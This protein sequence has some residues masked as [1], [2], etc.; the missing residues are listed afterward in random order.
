M[1]TTTKAKPMNRG[2]TALTP[3]WTRHQRFGPSTARAGRS[4]SSMP[5]RVPLI[6]LCINFSSLDRGR[7]ATLRRRP[8]EPGLLTHAD[9]HCC[10]HTNIKLRRAHAAPVLR[11]AAISARGFGRASSFLL[12]PRLSSPERSG[13]VPRVV[14][15]YLS[16]RCASPS[17][18][19][20][21]LIRAPALCNINLSHLSSQLDTHNTRNSFDTSQIK[22]HPD[23]ESCSCSR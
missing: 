12:H 13:S 6:A 4:G 23:S 10:D 9:S 18:V 1:P 5:P 15:Q 17:D 8:D 16:V 20:V 14:K 7:M 3:L 11:D 19:T 2:D 22:W 21:D